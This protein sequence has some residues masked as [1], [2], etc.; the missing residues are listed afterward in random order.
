MA[1]GP[2]PDTCCALFF[3]ARQNGRWRSPVTPAPH[4]FLG[5]FRFRPFPPLGFHLGPKAQPLRC[6]SDA[7]EREK[8]RS[9][10]QGCLPLAVGTYDGRWCFP[11][12]VSSPPSLLGLL[13]FRPFP[14]FG[15]LRDAEA[16]PHWRPNGNGACAKGM[17][18]GPL[19]F[20]PPTFGFSLGSWVQ[21]D[22]C[23]SCAGERAKGRSV[24]Q[25]CLPPADGHLHLYPYLPLQ[26]E[27]T[28][29]VVPSAFEPGKL[30]GILYSGGSSLGR[31][32]P[33]VPG[34][35]CFGSVGPFREKSPWA[36]YASGSS[37]MGSRI[38]CISKC[39]APLGLLCPES[40][41]CPGLATMAGQER[42]FVSAE[43]ASPWSA[44]AKLLP[45]P[46]EHI[47]N[48]LVRAEFL[49]SFQMDLYGPLL[50]AWHGHAWMWCK[51]R[52]PS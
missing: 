2:P 30:P 12:A 45:V 41:V 17:T 52:W 21:P 50:P 31:R 36:R 15:F 25:G 16:Q 11:L 27:H 47:L 44:L 35:F 19:W 20:R 14:L 3:L 22:R 32:L 38:H 1:L 51:C 28:V 29:I 33:Y 49:D 48:V 23:H 13:G 39:F 24:A 6:H 10:A 4:P 46:G 9:V 18:V 8:G 40:T 5:P 7:G 26:A 42:P 43:D 37:F 34:S